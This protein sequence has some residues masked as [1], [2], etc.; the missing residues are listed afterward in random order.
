MLNEE[1]DMNQ[2]CFDSSQFN[3]Q[4]LLKTSFSSGLTMRQNHGSV[5]TLQASGH[6]LH[7][8][9]H[10]TMHTLRSGVSGLGGLVVEVFAFGVLGLPVFGPKVAV[11]GTRV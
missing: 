1:K 11:L 8:L 3:R 9:M 10:L 6:G 5:Q 4:Q 7:K 2:E